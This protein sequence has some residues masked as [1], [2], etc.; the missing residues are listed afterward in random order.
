MQGSR[1]DGDAGRLTIGLRALAS[2]LPD[3]VVGLD[4]FR[5]FSSILPG[6]DMF[7]RERRWNTA[8][9]AAESQAVAAARAALDRAGL[10]AADIDF[11]V[12]QNLGGQFITPGIGAYIKRALG[13]RMETPALNIQQVCAG[14]LDGCRIAWDAIRA[15]PERVRHVLVVNSTAWR[16][17]EWG[18]DITCPSSI[19]CGDGAVAGVVSAEAVRLEFLSYVNRTH[20]EIY[21]DLIV[22]V[23]GPANPDLLRHTN[24]RPNKAV[25]IVSPRFPEWMGRTGRFLPVWL[26]P[27][28]AEAA[29]VELA[30]IAHVVPHQAQGLTI[31]LWKATAEAEIGLSPA[32]WSENWHRYGNMGGADSAVN[33]EHL[34]N[35]V[36]VKDGA[37]IAYFSPGGAGHSPTMMLRAR[38]G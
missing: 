33:L 10:E 15:D 5:Y 31:E 12:S 32:L 27:K 29:G 38:A 30:D 22:Q 25:M 8:L 9:D 4:R 17:G 1:L 35:Q 18:V 20:D 3:D 23:A 11:I 36:G 2:Y 16:T 6:F 26:I 19:A 28:A 14:F 37:L 34:V 21:E 7:P 24:L 13:C